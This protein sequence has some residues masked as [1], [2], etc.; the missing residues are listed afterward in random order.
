MDIDIAS[1]Y[2]NQ[3]VHDLPRFLSALRHVVDARVGITE[4]SHKTGLSRTSLYKTLSPTGN[5]GIFTILLIISALD[6]KLKVVKRHNG[7]KP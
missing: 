2:L 5:P 3:H 6:L 4:L 1:A 7:N